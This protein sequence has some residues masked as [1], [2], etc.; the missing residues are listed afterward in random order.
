MIRRDQVKGSRRALGVFASLALH[1]PLLECDETGLFKSMQN[2]I[3]GA[4]REP[5]AVFRQLV[6]QPCAVDGLLGDKVMLHK[7]V[8]KNGTERMVHVND[9]KVASRG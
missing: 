6:H 1:D 9:V 2:R 8:E 7:S 3:Q 4:R 5:M